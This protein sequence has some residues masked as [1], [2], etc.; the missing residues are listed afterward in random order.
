MRIF[1]AFILNIDNLTSSVSFLARQRQDFGLCKRLTI[2]LAPG[3]DSPSP[4]YETFLLKAPRN[5]H[6]TYRLTTSCLC[7]SHFGS[8]SQRFIVHSYVAS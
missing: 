5:R 7:L 6:C 8:E 3:L 4:S 2:F 1:D